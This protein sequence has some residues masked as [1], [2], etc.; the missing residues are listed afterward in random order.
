MKDRLG[1]SFQAQARANPR[2]LPAPV[3]ASACS[4]IGAR[5]RPPDVGGVTRPE[6]YHEAGLDETADSRRARGGRPMMIQSRVP[7]IAGDTTQQALKRTKEVSCLNY[8][9]QRPTT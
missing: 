3:L 5:D 8:K 4:Q 1:E 9:F 6:A 2:S 7:T